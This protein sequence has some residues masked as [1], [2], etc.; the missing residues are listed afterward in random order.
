MSSDSLLTRASNLVSYNLYKA[1]TDPDA[2][3]YADEQAAA[4]KQQDIADAKA[5]EEKKVVEAAEAKQ[6]ANYK[7]ATYDTSTFITQIIKYIGTAF[8][9][10]IYILLALYTGHIAANDA[11]GRAPSYRTLY[12]IYGTVFSIFVLPYYIIQ[13]MRG[14]SVKSYA[15]LPLREGVVPQGLEGFFQSFYTFLP[16]NE[17]I[18][19]TTNFQT[20]LREAIV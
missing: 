13:W 4:R 14:I 9:S 18:A 12:F 8:A 1:T 3:R 15:I 20:A 5:A 2:Q 19:A 7:E 10:S 6:K 11:I 16:D 17:S